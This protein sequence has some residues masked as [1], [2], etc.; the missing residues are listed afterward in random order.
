MNHRVRDFDA[1]RKPVEDQATDFRFENSN[2]FGKVAQ[3]LL[4]PVNRCGQMAFERI[5]DLQKL[6]V[7]GM[8]HQQRGW[9]EDLGLQVGT[10][11]RIGISLEYSRVGTKPCRAG[12]L[13]L[14]KYCHRRICLPLA[15]GRIVRG[16]DGL[17]Q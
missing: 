13:F 16:M 6:F 8:P 10:E 14:G 3:V 15:N 9:P 2:Q 1:S 11:E 7:A 12:T 4:G 17:G 5:C